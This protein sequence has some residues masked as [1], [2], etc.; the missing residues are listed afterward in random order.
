MNY[1]KI[2]I[3]F[4]MVSIVL[5][6]ISLF[7]FFDITI[8]CSDEVSCIYPLIEVVF[9]AVS[10]CFFLLLANIIHRFHK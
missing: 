5:F 4:F 6:L 10:S 3:I 8:S 2:S 7:L 9:I 1:R